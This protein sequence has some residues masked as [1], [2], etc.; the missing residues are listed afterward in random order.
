MGSLN[1]RQ[2]AQGKFGQAVIGISMIA[3]LEQILQ[4]TEHLATKL[5]HA[6]EREPT[7]KEINESIDIFMNAARNG[8]MD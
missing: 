8:F 1:C 3:I 2:T 5:P 4:R 6:K 7:E